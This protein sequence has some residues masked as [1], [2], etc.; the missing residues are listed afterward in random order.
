MLSLHRRYYVKDII[1]IV[2]L[3]LRKYILKHIR[4]SMSVVYSEVVRKL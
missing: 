3:F 4:Y 1:Y 2:S